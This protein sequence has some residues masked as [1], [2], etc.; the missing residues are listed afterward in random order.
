MNIQQNSVQNNALRD[1]M[2]QINGPERRPANEQNEQPPAINNEIGQAL[3][4]SK[5]WSC[6]AVGKLA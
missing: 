3:E 2:E 4:C 5:G 6:I 1:A